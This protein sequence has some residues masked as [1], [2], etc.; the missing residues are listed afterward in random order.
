MFTS[1]S[2][3][4]TVGVDSETHIVPAAQSFLRKFLV[5]VWAIASTGLHPWC[6]CNPA[7]FCMHV[8]RSPNCATGSVRASSLP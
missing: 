4:G 7:F 5:D 8:Y 2:I 6:R 3:K 1:C